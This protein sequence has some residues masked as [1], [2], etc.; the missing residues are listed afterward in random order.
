MQ[1]YNLTIFIMCLPQDD[2]MNI[3]IFIIFLIY[4]HVFF[5]QIIGHNERGF[6]EFNDT[7]FSTDLHI[8]LAKMIYEKTEIYVGRERTC[9][10]KNNMCPH[11]QW[12][13]LIEARSY[14]DIVSASVTPFLVGQQIAV[15]T[16]KTLGEQLWWKE[17]VWWL[18]FNSHP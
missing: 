3:F 17:W 13:T 15:M 10:C 5:R 9:F 7:F 11:H 8:S 6:H 2:N 12:D 18:W 16:Q 1:F 14:K 4:F